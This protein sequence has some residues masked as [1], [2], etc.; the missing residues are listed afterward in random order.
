MPFFA[1][2]NSVN[3]SAFERTDMICSDLM[4]RV[5]QTLFLS[6]GLPNLSFNGNHSSFYRELEA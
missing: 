4:L 2:A 6:D 1:A 5:S 3:V